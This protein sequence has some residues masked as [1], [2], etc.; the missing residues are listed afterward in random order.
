MKF[1][2]DAPDGKT[3]FRIETEA[4]AALESDQMNHAVEK[5]FRAE[6]ERARETYQPTSASYIE[7]DIGLNA[8]LQRVMPWF[9]T[10]RDREGTALATAML[11]PG[12]R[13]QEDFRIIIVA[14]GNTDPYPEHEAAIAA[15]GKH[16]GIALD[17]DRCF[18]YQRTQG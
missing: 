12:G 4:E 11:P 18:P 9:L 17:R 16:F 2:C 6:M 15:L 5:Y 7:R 8:H 10:L 3:W 13:D 14:R 1:V